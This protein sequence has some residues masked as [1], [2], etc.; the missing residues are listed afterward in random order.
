MFAGDREPDLKRF[1]AE[2][3]RSWI[4]D[5]E[6]VAPRKRGKNGGLVPNAKK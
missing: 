5:W 4:A 2:A 6:P 1:R 3:C